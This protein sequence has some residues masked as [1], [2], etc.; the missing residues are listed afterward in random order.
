MKQNNTNFLS[1]FVYDDR[2][3]AHYNLGHK[4]EE[5]PEVPERTERIYLNLNK[6]GYIDRMV[7][8]PSRPAL[9]SELLYAHTEGF[10]ELMKKTK[11]N[12]YKPFNLF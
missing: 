11:S 8:I 12:I 9:D 4:M 6:K 3:L 7:H 2:D 1:G 10:L 5:H